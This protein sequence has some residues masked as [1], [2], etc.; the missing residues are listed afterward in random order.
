MSVRNRFM[1][2][3]QIGSERPAAAARDSSVESVASNPR[4]R[5][6]G[7]N[8]TPV[9]VVESEVEVGPRA[10]VL[11]AKNHDGIR[12]VD[13]W[14]QAARANVESH[15]LEA[16]D[17]VAGMV[18]STDEVGSVSEGTVDVAHRG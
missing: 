16:M 4:S 5:S 7:G 18:A 11:G 12:S 10:L 8:H 17:E 3:D 13:D 2:L 1:G 6:S 15:N 9:E 14:T